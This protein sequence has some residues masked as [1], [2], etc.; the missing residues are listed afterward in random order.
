MG[1]TAHQHKKAITRRKRYKRIR[2]ICIVINE[3]SRVCG[4]CSEEAMN[5]N[6]RL[7]HGPSMLAV[8]RKFMECAINNPALSLL[9]K[10]LVIG[11]C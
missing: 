7:L 8:R 6:C 3:E 2:P 10:H 5:H 9:M 1:F 11:Q 4:K